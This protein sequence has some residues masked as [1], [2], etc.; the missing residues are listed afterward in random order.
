MGLERN[1]ILNKR[2]RIV[3]ILGQGGMGSVYRAEDLNLN[4][5]LAVKENLFTTDEYSRQFRREATILA[6][7]RHPNL[8]RVTDHFEIPNQGQYLIMDYIEGEDLRQRMDR[9]GRLPEEQVIAIGIAICDA[10]TYLHTRRPQVL[11]RDIKPGNVKIT[12]DGRVF[13]VDFGLAKIVEVGQ[14]TTTGARAMTP[15]YSPPEQYGTARTDERSDVYSLGATLYAALCGAIPEDGLARAMNQTELTPV[16]KRSPKISRR[17]AA[18]IEKALN[19]QPDGRYQSADELKQALMAAA[20]STVRQGELVVTPPPGVEEDSEPPPA[21]PGPPGGN[22]KNGKDSTGAPLRPVNRPL[23]IPAPARKPRT[24]SRRAQGCLLVVALAALLVGAGG[25]LA[26]TQIP[27]F[28]AQLAGWL[29]PVLPQTMIAFLAPP[30][31]TLTTA[32]T[33][34]ATLPAATPTEALESARLTL[35][36]LATQTPSPTGTLTPMPTPTNTPTQ[37]PV[38]S[39]TPRFLGGGSGDVAF[40]SDW[41]GIPQIYLARVDGGPTRQ[42]TNLPGGSCQPDWS[43]DGQKMVF[44]S[45]CEGRSEIYV[46]A[47]LFAINADGSSLTAL[48]GV[49]AGDYDPAWSPDGRYIAFTTLRSTGKAQVAVLDLTDGTYIVLASNGSRNSQPTWSPTGAQIAYIST[50]INGERIWLMDGNGANQAAFS[51]TDGI[52]SQPVWGPLGINIYFTFREALG[53]LP[54]LGATPVNQFGR[55][56]IAPDLVPRRDPDVSPDGQWIAYESWPEGGDHDIW[57]MRVTSD[58]QQLLASTPFEDYHPRWRP[59]FE[60]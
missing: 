18:A 48:L 13:L 49:A 30:T 1:S 46:G 35:A 50:Q 7:L 9:E 34:T 26:Y 22:G 28:P 33:A 21:T 60:D 43:P 39:P 11:H 6:G 20:N 45:P 56:P 23:E 54:S 58:D 53:S 19:V 59:A 40:V 27:G 51:A 37:T 31:P 42:L 32:P 3:E 36:A 38:P 57:M 24:T 5:Q 8:P 41:S 44:I 17:L 15:G 52:Y 47:S 12:P 29:S 25:M 4:V 14:S 10:L 2:Y 55:L 16:R